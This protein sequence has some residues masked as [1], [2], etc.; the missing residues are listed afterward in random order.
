[1]EFWRIIVRLYGSALPTSGTPAAVP[2][3]L[4]QCRAVVDFVSDVIDAAESSCVRE[5]NR[6]NFEPRDVAVYAAVKLT[7]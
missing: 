2:T 1:M 7:L 4:P 3:L 6:F 5:R